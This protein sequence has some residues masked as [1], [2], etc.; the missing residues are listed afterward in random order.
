MVAPFENEPGAGAAESTK[1]GT[2][3]DGIA[4]LAIAAYG[5]SLRAMG[6]CSTDACPALGLGLKHDLASIAEDL[7]SCQS[8]ETLESA[9]FRTCQHLR[10]WGQRT[11][12]HYREKTAEVKGLLLVMARTAD[13]VIERDQRCAGQ[14]G[15]I[16]SKLQ[17][18]GSLEDLTEIR[19]MIE[20]SA[21]DLRQSVDR[22]AAEGEQAIAE[23]QAQ[24]CSYRVKLEEAEEFASRDGLTG[25]RNRFWVENQIELRIAKGRPMS[26]AI[27]D[28]DAFKGINDRHGHLAGDEVLKQ[29]ARELRSASRSTDVI[30]RWGGDEFILVLDC[31]LG[32]AEPQIERLRAWVCSDYA[33]VGRN[34]SLKLHVSASIGLAE[35]APGETLKDLLARADAAMYGHKAA[36]RKKENIRR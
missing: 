9:Q 35:G 12:G 31:P 10:E 13:A 14:I 17:T 34:G 8:R 32:E 29:F 16:T 4:P 11:A 27:V 1:L 26:L 2:V 36:S 24:V 6:D 3:V 19:A 5:A 21:V 7:S 20:Q 30:G 25:L 15:E 33:V 22:M 18:I 23:L 28:I